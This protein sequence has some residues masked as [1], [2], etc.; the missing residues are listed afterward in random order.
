[1]TQQCREED[2][3]AVRAKYAEHDIPAEL[4]TYLPDLPERLGWSHLVIG[5]AGAST[6]AELTCAGRP[7]ILVPLP[8]A[9][10]DHQTHNVKEMVEAGGA[11]SIPQPAFTPKELA[12]QMQKMAL[13]TGA[14]ENAA[15]KA[16]KC[17][18]PTAVRDLA[19]LVESFGSA[20]LGDKM[21]TKEEKRP[22]VSSQQPAMAKEVAE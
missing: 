15:K 5:R 20:P 3:E 6:V 13:Q 12:K 21:K 8:I 11:R 1:V 18:R 7:A 10:D 2:I 17:G 9:T 16:W 19:D 22:L 4:A 14:L